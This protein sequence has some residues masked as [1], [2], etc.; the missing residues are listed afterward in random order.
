[1]KYLLLAAAF[2]GVLGY[3][4][5]GRGDAN[6]YAITP[7]DVYQALRSA[8]VEKG[9]GGVFGNLDTSVSGNGDSVITW[10]ASGSHASRR[11][12]AT[13]APEG[14]DQSRLT[15]FCDGGGAGDGAAAGMVS[16]MNRK[17]L[18]E[19]IDAT[20]DKR[21]YDARMAQGST[22]SGWPSDARQA[23]GSYGPAVGDALKM[24]RD[25][26]QM[27][28]DIDKLEKAPRVEAGT[29]PNVQFQPGKPMVNV[30]PNRR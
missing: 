10:N 11:C 3:A 2:L 4:W 13:I 27:E 5:F 30:N 28:R 7:A 18:I 21:P 8:P 1:M 19:H 9:N 6:V 12:E 25:L 29:S 22:A 26:K 14:T 15:A 20:L 17:A 24:E 23:D 16:G